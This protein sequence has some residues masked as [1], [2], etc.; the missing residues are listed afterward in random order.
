MKKIVR[1]YYSRK[2]KKQ[3]KKNIEKAKNELEKYSLEKVSLSDP[4]CRMMQSK[5]K[6][7]ELSYNVRLG[8]SKNQIIVSNDVCQDKHDAHQFIPQIKNIQE[9]IKLNDEIKVGADSGYSDAENNEIIADGIKYRFRGIYTRKNGK[10]IISYYN[11][12]IKRKKD[13]PFFFIER[14]QMKEEMQTDEGRKIYSLRKITVEPVYGHIKQNLDF[15]EFL[16]RG[17]E[18]VKIEMNLISI[19]H[20]LGKIHRMMRKNKEIMG[21]SFSY[22]T[23]FR[24]FCV[25]EI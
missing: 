6:F 24:N 4:E 7:A 11:K 10:K 3:V 2:N 22:F 15:R 9:N 19:A 5:K 8:V 25:Y 18:K 13:V 23:L 21:K 12:E 17:L 14:L 16:L 20:N 1:E